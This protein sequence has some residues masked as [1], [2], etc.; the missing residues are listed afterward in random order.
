LLVRRDGWILSRIWIRSHVACR[1][2]K[3]GRV[4]PC[5]LIVFQDG[6]LVRGFHQNL[7]LRRSEVFVVF[8]LLR[9]LWHR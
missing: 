7:P 6:G 3:T 1:V 5:C 4:N 9:L 2:K 8:R